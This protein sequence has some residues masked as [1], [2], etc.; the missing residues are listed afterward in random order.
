M[1][2]EK[3]R[4]FA[5]SL[6]TQLGELAENL[7]EDQAQRVVKVLAP[8]QPHIQSVLAGEASGA[9]ARAVID[10]LI[11]ARD[12]AKTISGIVEYRWKKVGEDWLVS[13]PD[14][15]AGE[16]VTVTSSKGKQEVTIESVVGDFGVPRREKV[17][18]NV[19]E[20]IWHNKNGDLI[21]VAKTR[22][23][24]L[25]GKLIDPETAKRTYLGKRGLLGLTDRLTLEE[26]KEFGKAT[27]NC[28]VCGRELTNDKNPGPDGLTSVERGLGPICMTRL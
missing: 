12:K 18:E 15:Q 24:Q 11:Q 23:G 5:I 27:G 13:G 17:P 20:G 19:E 7:S 1:T 9:N 14:L 4:S 6:H 22:N 26:A 25:V 28:M 3:Q 8:V 10:A 16:T 2:S 21:E